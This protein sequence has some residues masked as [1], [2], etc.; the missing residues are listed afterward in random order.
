MKKRTGFVSNSSSTSFIIGGTKEE[1][2]ELPSD[3]DVKKS[4]EEE[5]KEDARRLAV[6]DSIIYYDIK[7]MLKKEEEE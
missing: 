2:K 6:W 3:F 1:N 4:I 5:D 7:A